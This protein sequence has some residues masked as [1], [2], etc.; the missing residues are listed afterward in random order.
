LI[1]VLRGEMSLVGPAP[2]SAAD[3]EP[4]K[5]SKRYYLS[6][7]PGVLGIASIADADAEDPGHYKIYALSWSLS[8]DF[9]ILWDGVR[10]LRDKGKLWQPSFKLKRGGRVPARRR[11]T[12]I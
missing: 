12:S 8:A 3:L 7:R 1:N 5:T 2:L 9:L 4:L 6:A 10:S 11:S